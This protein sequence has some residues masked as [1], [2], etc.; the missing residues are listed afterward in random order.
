MYIVH[1]LRCS[2]DNG[3]TA[4]LNFN[5]EPVCDFSTLLPSKLCSVLVMCTGL[6][7][8]IVMSTNCRCSL[9]LLVDPSPL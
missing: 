9:L 1:V 4:Q 3:Y 7:I 6:N 8:I 2:L 5:V